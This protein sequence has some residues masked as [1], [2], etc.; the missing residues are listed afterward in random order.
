MGSLRKKEIM[1]FLQKQQNTS[2]SPYQCSLVYRTLLGDSY[3]TK[4]GNV[5]IQQ[6]IEKKQYIMWLFNQLE[7]LT[8]GNPPRLVSNIDK[9]SNTWTQS[10]RFYTKCL[11]KEW[12]P[13]FYNE[14]GKKQLP[15]N[16]DKCLDELSIALWFLDD[17]SRYSG[18]KAGAYLTLDSYTLDE[19]QSI[20]H[21]FSTKFQITTHLYKAGITRKGLVQR[22]IIF[23]G[24]DYKTFYDLVYPIVSQIPSMCQKKLVE[25]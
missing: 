22:R 19:I 6:S 16:F 12:R 18:V 23:K 8:T 13:L 17:G 24:K 2:V 14:S 3:L 15:N 25:V 20:Q 4:R 9:R 10:Y 5:Q 1:S 21:T 7:T 11:F